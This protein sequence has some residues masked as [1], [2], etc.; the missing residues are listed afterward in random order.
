[1]KF[2]IFAKTIVPESPPSPGQETLFK[3]RKPR[4]GEFRSVSWW[5]KKL[6]VKIGDIVLFG[7]YSGTEIKFNDREFLVMREEDIIGIIN[8]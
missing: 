7:K 1:M 6:E 3:G 5:Q 4:N 2:A 8:S